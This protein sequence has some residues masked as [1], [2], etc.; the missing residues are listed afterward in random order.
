MMYDYFEASDG[1]SGTPMYRFQCWVIRH[2]REHYARYRE[3]PL[4][5][6]RL[7]LQDWNQLPCDEQIAILGIANPEEIEAEITAAS[8]EV[9]RD[10]RLW[11]V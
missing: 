1:L 4:K 8:E 11:Q 5:Q 10:R 3:E 2:V 7:A 6:L 9:W